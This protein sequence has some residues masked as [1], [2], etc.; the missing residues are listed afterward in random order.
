MTSYGFTKDDRELIAGL[1]RQ[2]VDYVVVDDLKFDSMKRFLT[3]F[4]RQRVRSFLSRYRF[5]RDSETWLVRV[6]P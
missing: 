5:M 4:I 2:G 6:K 3:A 1:R